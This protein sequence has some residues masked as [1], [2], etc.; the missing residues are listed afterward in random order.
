MFFL[1]PFQKQTTTHNI[2]PPPK[3]KRIPPNPPK[4]NG[5]AAILEVQQHLVTSRPWGASAFEMCTIDQTSKA[6]HMTIF[7]NLSHIKA[8]LP[9]ANR[10]PPLPPGDNL[11]RRSSPKRG[12]NTSK[13]VDRSVL[14]HDSSTQKL[15]MST[16]QCNWTVTGV[17]PLIF[18]FFFIHENNCTAWP[19]CYFH[20]QRLHK[21][22]FFLMIHKVRF[23][24]FMDI[25]KR[26]NTNPLGGFF[27][28]ALW[29]GILISGE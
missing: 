19:A 27:M 6:V 3:K 12:R 15:P 14:K 23:E 5:F 26:I 16:F 18:Q 17:F 24:F 1:I 20:D 7:E 25:H 4:S 11:R 10:E 22:S 21:D 29:K 9:C 13:I 28:A 2:T 8:V